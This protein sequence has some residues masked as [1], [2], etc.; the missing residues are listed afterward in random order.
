MPMGRMIHFAWR[1]VALVRF[2]LEAGVRFGG[3]HPARF[4]L[5]V[6]GDGDFLVQKRF[7]FHHRQFFDGAVGAAILRTGVLCQERWK[8]Q[9]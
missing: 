4:V 9:A 7:G 6:D 3:E 1:D 8:Q 5:A 2:H